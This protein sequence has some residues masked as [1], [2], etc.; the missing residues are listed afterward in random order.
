MRVKYLNVKYNQNIEIDELK[1]N[2]AESFLHLLLEMHFLH[3]FNVV[4]NKIKL[5]N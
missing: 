1:Q 5:I 3:H 2:F 4:L